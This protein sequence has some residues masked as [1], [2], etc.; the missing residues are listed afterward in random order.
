MGLEMLAI[1]AGLLAGA[2]V[3]HRWLEW[4]PYQPPAEPLNLQLPTIADGTFIPMFWGTV[5]IRTPLLAWLGDY[6][7]YDGTN[8]DPPPGSSPYGT[9]FQY[10]ADMFFNCG[11]PFDGVSTNRLHRIW[12]GDLPLTYA[13]ENGHG[14]GLDTGDGFAMGGT[15]T[16]VANNS[17]VGIGVSTIAGLIEFL[18]GKPTQQLVDGTGTAQTHAG[19]VML[20][21]G[22]TADEIPS[23]RGYASVLLW[24][25]GGTSWILG[26]SPTPPTPSF[27]MSSVPIDPSYCIAGGDLDI[28]GNVILDANPAQVILDILTGKFG[29]LGLDP[30][31]I[32][33]VSFNASILTLLEEQHGFSLVDPGGRSADN[34][35][36]DILIQIDGA[37]AVNPATGQIRLKLIRAS[38]V[39]SLASIP[40]INPDNCEAITNF[41]ASGWPGLVN[42]VRVTYTDRSNGYNDSTITAINQA[43]ISGQDGLAHDIALAFPGCCSGILAQTLAA[44]ELSVMSKPMSKC[45][46]VCNRSMA[47]LMPGDPVNLLWPEYHIS[48]GRVFRV[49]SISRG[50]LEDGKVTIDLIEDYFYTWRG[51]TVVGSTLGAFGAG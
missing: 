21:G 31:Y 9:T 44:R 18:N 49:A 42:K 11:I 23:Y 16:S 6:H 2:Y 51:V 48:G 27:E 40:V 10:Q 28:F 25:S 14:F 30:S 38:D 13:P 26:E 45:T 33:L 29:K 47:G 3:Y 32:D 35:I 46:A 24:A 39:A 43:N 1:D 17:L 8:L 12:F 4:Q 19:Q 37:M 5:R 22:L 15:N 36:S 20:S 34:I 41:A 50:L 7:V